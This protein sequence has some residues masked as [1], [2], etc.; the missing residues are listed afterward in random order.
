MIVAAMGLA[1]TDTL[2]SYD[3]DFDRIPGVTR[4]IPGATNSE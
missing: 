4:Q 2:Y 1:G 3:A